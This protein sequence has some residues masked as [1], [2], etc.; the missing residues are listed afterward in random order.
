MR[1]IAV[2]T[3]TRADYGLLYRVIEGL[4]E[5]SEVELQLIVTGAHLSPE[6]GMTVKDI[7]KDGFPIAERVEMLLDSDT[8]EAVA[9]SMGR[10][11]VGI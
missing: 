11:V 6:F 9:V 10:A 2:I 8:E 3:G 5:D 1:K 4:H 7:E